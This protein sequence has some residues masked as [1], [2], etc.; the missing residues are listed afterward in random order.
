ML[1]ALS[2]ADQG[3]ANAFVDQA[4]GT[5]LQDSE[6]PLKTKLLAVVSEC[7]RMLDEE[8]TERFNEYWGTPSANNDF[9]LLVRKLRK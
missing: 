2:T 9:K 1:A 7:R 3:L 4:F 8:P 5:V 6:F